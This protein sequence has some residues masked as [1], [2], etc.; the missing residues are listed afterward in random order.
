M[1]R[2]PAPLD[3]P[4]INEIGD[5][6]P[7]WVMYFDGLFRGDTGTD[8]TPVFVGLGSTETPTITERY[9]QLSSNLVYFRVKITPATNTTSTAGSTYINNFPLSIFG[10]GACLAVAPT[11]GLGVGLGVA[12]AAS[13]RIFTPA[14]SATTVPITI[15]GLLEAR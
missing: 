15:L 12:D 8:W 5:L 3:Q 4:I 9:Y 6:P 2:N 11:A 13:G 10:D 7:E 1:S 14:W